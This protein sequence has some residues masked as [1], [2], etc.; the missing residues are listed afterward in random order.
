MACPSNRYN[1]VGKLRSENMDRGTHFK[2]Y[3]SELSDLKPASL[4]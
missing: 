1:S 4:R 3:G 2:F